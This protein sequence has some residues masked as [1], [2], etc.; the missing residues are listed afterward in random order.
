MFDIAFS[1]FSPRGETLEYRGCLLRSL[2]AAY[3]RQAR[4][5]SE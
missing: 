2:I 4:F 3:R 5:Y 1:G